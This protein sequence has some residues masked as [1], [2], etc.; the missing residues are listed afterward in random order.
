VRRVAELMRRNMTIT[1]KAE[2]FSRTSPFD[3]R[4]LYMQ[5]YDKLVSMIANGTWKPGEMIPNEIQL[6][7]DVGVSVGTMRKALQVMVERALLSRHQGR[8]TYVADQ[9]KHP[10]TPY[11]SLRDERHDPLNWRV[12]KSEMAA[13]EAEP[14]EVSALALRPGA[15]V[16][17]LRRQLVDDA[18]ATH[19]LEYSTLP[20]QRFPGLTVLEKDNQTLPIWML[21]RRSGILLG[22]SSE[23]VQLFSAS[24]REAKQ[25]GI[26]TGTPLLMLTRIILSLENVPVEFRIAYCLPGKSVKYLSRTR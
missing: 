3:I 18:T 24:A 26:P 16:I 11:D 2:D 23:N 12:T 9:D 6:A 7:R 22:A 4:P 20:Q 13:G 15:P 14:A 10:E 25:L 21:A 1:S 17:R 8:G 5:V 19:L